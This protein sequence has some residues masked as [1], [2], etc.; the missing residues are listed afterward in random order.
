MSF[1]LL[2]IRTTKETL[3]D[4][5]RILLRNRES[6]KQIGE[7]G[8]EFVRECHHPRKIAERTIRAYTG[9]CAE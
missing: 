8:M 2:R 9:T 5:L 4:D 6:W 3:V 7:A 1:G